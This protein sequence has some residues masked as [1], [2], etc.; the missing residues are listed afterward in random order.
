LDKVHTKQSGNSRLLLSQT[1]REFLAAIKQAIERC[2]GVELEEILRLQ[3]L[4]YGFYLKLRWYEGMSKDEKVAWKEN[5]KNTI[6]LTHTLY[7]Y[8]LPLYVELRVMGYSHED[9]VR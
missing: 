9:L 4:R 2:P 3:T 6:K 5:L 1:P 8:V 7:E